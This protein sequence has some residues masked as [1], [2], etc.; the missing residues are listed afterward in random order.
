MSQ[1]PIH[2]QGSEWQAVLQQLH[3]LIAA[4]DRQDT[5]SLELAKGFAALAGTFLEAME[6]GG[7]SSTRFR[8]VV[9]ALDLKTPSSKLKLFLSDG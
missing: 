9:K 4:F 8:A 6:S 1:A 2:R 7:T 3:V 5:T